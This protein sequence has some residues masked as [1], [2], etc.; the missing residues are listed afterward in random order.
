MKSIVHD[1]SEKAV[2]L[3]DIFISVLG[4]ASHEKYLFSVFGFAS[5]EKF[6]YPRSATPHTVHSISLRK[7]RFFGTCNEMYYYAIP[8]G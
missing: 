5:H 7:K 1:S 6:C 2:P 8:W 4:Y 3:L